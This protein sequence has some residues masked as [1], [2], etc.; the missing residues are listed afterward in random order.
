MWGA[1]ELG[2]AVWGG[3]E[4]FVPCL[5]LTN[6]LQLRTHVW[7]EY[8]AQQAAQVTLG[9]HHH[10][11]TLKAPALAFASNSSNSNLTP[12]CS[13]RVRHDTQVTHACQLVPLCLTNVCRCTA[14]KPTPVHTQQIHAA[15]AVK[16]VQF[17]QTTRHTM[18]TIHT[19]WH[20]LSPH[21]KLQHTLP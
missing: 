8:A 1:A 17:M 21:N 2:C 11:V 5:G 12:G 16:K 6:A 15:S 4:G 9:A 20:V 18:Y 10:S 14:Y 19:G 13:T 3:G 7:N